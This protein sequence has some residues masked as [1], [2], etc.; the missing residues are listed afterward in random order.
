[1]EEEM[2]TLVVVDAQN[3]FSPDG[4]RP[5]P[6]HAS[7]LEVIRRRVDVARHEGRPIAWIRHHN[8]PDEAPAF[9]PGSWGA[10]LSPGFGPVSGY[11]PEVELQKDVFGAFSGTELESWMESGGS[12]AVLLVGF[13]AH[14]CLS[15]TARECLM[16]GLTVSVDPQGT[17][18][19]DLEHPLLGKETADEVRRSALLHLSQLGVRIAPPL[20]VGAAATAEAKG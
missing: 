2:E 10:E 4:K 14:M 3:E 9:L 11:G 12:D 6:N 5:V 1:L 7:A 13:Y 16:R 17:G 18:G 20:E 19:C 15:S 8:R